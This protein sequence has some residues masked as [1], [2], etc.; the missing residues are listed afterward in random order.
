MLIRKIRDGIE[1]S[2][3]SAR[4]VGDDPELDLA[5]AVD[6]RQR[7]DG[8]AAT[9]PDGAAKAYQE[10]IDDSPSYVVSYLRLAALRAEK[11]D[12]TAAK[13][14]LGKGLAAD[15]MTEDGKA[16]LNAALAKLG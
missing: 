4:S 11:G 3:G 14:V 12:K 2:Q 6:A 7:G 15:G 10:A 8:L 5:D 9:D 1:P 16:Q 13:E